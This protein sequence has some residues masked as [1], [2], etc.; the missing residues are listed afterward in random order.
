MSKAKQ[1]EA[2]NPL[3][4]AVAPTGLDAS[5]A[6][7]ALATHISAM[8][9]DFRTDVKGFFKERDG[10]HRAQALRASLN[11]LVFRLQK[12]ISHD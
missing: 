3:A 8:E 7:N 4:V 5:A 9:A 6:V 12:F 2:K 1:S 10:N 11:D